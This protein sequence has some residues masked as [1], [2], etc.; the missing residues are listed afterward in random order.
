MAATDGGVFAIF[1]AD[2]DY[3]GKHEQQWIINFCFI[4]LD[5]S[6][7]VKPCGVN[8]SILN[9]ERF[10]H[11]ALTETR[12]SDIVVDFSATADQRIVAASCAFL[13]QNQRSKKIRKINE[14]K[15]P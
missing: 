12:L 14:R 13:V 7:Y 5:S 10:Y 8:V 9:A 1:A 3:F 6:A 2:R 11:A 4:D 15:I